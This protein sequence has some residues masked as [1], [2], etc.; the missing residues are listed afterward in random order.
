MSREQSRLF[1]FCNPKPIH[2]VRE[3]TEG[4]RH[5]GGKVVHG[6]MTDWA[7]IKPQEGGIGILTSV[8]EGAE[9]VPADVLARFKS[10]KGL[11]RTVKRLFDG[12]KCVRTINGTVF[13]VPTSALKK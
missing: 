2:R 11:G 6:R 8:P 5:I 3:E 1:L 4:C 13:L 12:S 7:D 9:E 10:T